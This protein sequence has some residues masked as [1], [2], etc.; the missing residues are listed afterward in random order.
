M[1]DSNLNKTKGV[2]VVTES[3][4]NVQKSAFIQQDVE[5]KYSRWQAIKAYPWSSMYLV[6]ALWVMISV[7]FENGVGSMVVTIPT[8]RKDFGEYFDGEYVLD[9]NWQ[10]AISGG[11]IGSLVLGVV[12]GSYICDIF[13]RTKIMFVAVFLTFGFIALEYVATTI[14]VFFAG[15]FLNA[16][17]LG[18]LQS[19]GTTYIA[20]ISPLALRGMATAAVNL[21]F[22]IGPFIAVLIVNS[23]S[24]SPDR[25]AYRGIFLTQWA[26]SGISIVLLFFLPDSPYYYI[27]RKREDLAIKALEKLYKDE[28]LV[29]V[30]FCIVK[31]TIEEAEANKAASSGSFVECFNKANLKRTLVAVSP[32]L[33]Q[34]MSGLAYVGSYGTYYI[35]RSGFTTSQSFQL[36]CGAQALSIFGSIASWF[37]LDRWG[38]RFVV[39]YGMISLFILNILIAGLGLKTENKS[40]TTATAA[41]ITMYNFFFNSG[42]GPISY[43]INSEIPTSALRAKTVAL[44]IGLNNA[45]QCMWQFVLPYMFNP[46]EANMGSNI[47]F[48]FAACCFV[49]IFGYFF[50]LPET[51]NRS[52]KKLMKCI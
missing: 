16:F 11:P 2:I 15:K 46:D 19:V 21:S 30:Q 6:F 28:A 50:Y 5:H 39:L 3:V 26:F 8:F 44:G 33:M 24:D 45:F 47:N 41:L 49:S 43:V 14:E 48:I 52:S 42:I 32:F 12:L 29:Q 36:S 9:A 7:G 34:P 10:S 18:L 31:S 38:R 13:G 17:S 23:I 40:F 37:V 27:L 20:E 1:S 35:Q 4:D 51:A 25:I 22:G